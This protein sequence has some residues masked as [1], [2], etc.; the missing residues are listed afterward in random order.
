MTA[1]PGPYN[2]RVIESCFGCPVH[3]KSI[4]CQLPPVALSALN[5]L[6]QPSFYPAGVI[7]FVKGQSSRGLFMLCS[8]AAKL[9]DCSLEGR[10]VTLRLAE[11]GEVLGLGSVVANEPY[12]VS[13]ETLVPSQV[14][15]INRLQFMQFMRAHADVSLRVARHLSME[16]HKARQQTCLLALAPSTQAKVAEFLLSWGT[17]HGQQSADGLH[18]ILHMTQEEIGHA[19]GASRESVSRVLAD[20]RRRQLVRVN[21]GS[22]I[23]LQRDGL[24]SLMDTAPY[25]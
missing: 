17:T 19:I 25:K 5:S 8:G 21:G 22:V 7:L 24:E 20:F 12:Q 13:A 15:F 3:E 9:T 4:F 14:G 16:L 2:L 23:I 6:R 1:P 10:G 11:A 18:L